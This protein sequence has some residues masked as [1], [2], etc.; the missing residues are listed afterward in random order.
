SN[1]ALTGLKNGAAYSAAKAALVN[2]V[3]S[4][5]LETASANVLINAISPAPVETDL[6][7]DYEG[8]YLEFRKKYFEEFRRLSPTGKLVSKEEIS[9]FVQLLLSYSLEN[10]TGA[11]IVIDGGFS[12][13]QSTSLPEEK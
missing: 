8:E 7:S 10:F 4:V 11:N 6:E 2:L 12:T 5:A 13:A 3:K 9:H 1:V